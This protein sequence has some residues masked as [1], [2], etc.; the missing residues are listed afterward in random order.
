MIVSHVIT[1]GPRPQDTYLVPVR[2]GGGANITEDPSVLGNPFEIELAKVASNRSKHWVGHHFMFDLRMMGRHGIKVVGR[3]EDTGVNA[4]ILNEFQHSFSL[5]NSCKAVGAIP[6]LGS[7]LYEHLAAKFGG[8]AARR[9]QMGNYW[10][11][12][13]NDPIG[14]EYAAGDGVSTWDLLHK[15]IAK[16]DTERL[17]HI[18]TL[19]SDITRVVYRMT[20]RGIRVDTERLD[21]SRE[22]LA[23]KL[24]HARTLLPE[25]FSVRSPNAIK[26]ILTQHGI[27]EDTWPR[28]PPTAAMIK[29]GITIGNPQ[30]N[31]EFLTK[32]DIGKAIIAVR[33]YEHME[34]AFLA[35]LA[36][37]H[38]WPDNRVRATFN[39]AAGDDFGTV[40][41]RFSSNDPNLQQV[42]KRFQEMGEIARSP[43]VPDEGEEWLDADLSQCEPRILAHYSQSK[44]LI[45]G[46]T[47]IPPVDAHSSVAKAAGIDRESG[48]RLNQTLITG[49]GQAKV[50][51]MLGPEGKRIYDD[52]FEAMPEIKELQKKATGVFRRTRVLYS[53]LRRQARLDDPNQAY[54]AVNRLLQIGNADIIKKA[55]VDID[56]HYEENGDEVKLLNTVH[57]SLSSSV[58][59]TERG[60]KIAEHGLRLFTNFGPGRGFPMTVPMACDYA[61]GDTW[62]EATYNKS[63]R[64]TMGERVDDPAYG[65][66]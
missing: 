32:S 14:F 4:A 46:Y 42:P 19:E 62:A 55:M 24:K 5:E 56:K 65:D 66:L 61:Y 22:I 50:I 36:N 33:K 39:Q 17:S 20:T 48:K 37:Q 2:H 41:Y 29:K 6:K 34:S 58:P 51:A 47:S 59:K 49:G 9:D 64:K 38:L 44:V 10:K 8:E 45:T 21:R 35:P 31:E 53:L 1:L 23:G 54:K 3:V 63:G 18:R 7:E 28:L 27:T 57:D 13:G 15:Q 52:Y 60:R 12:A 26:S 16:L 25:D 43:F 40:T 30:F 11:L